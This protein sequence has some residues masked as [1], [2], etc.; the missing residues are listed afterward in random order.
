MK[1]MNTNFKKLEAD[2]SVAKNVNNLLMKKSVEIE[3]QCS[4]DAQEDMWIINM[5]N[6]DLLE[7]NKLFINESLC[8]ECKGI[9]V[10]C[11]NCGTGSE[12]I[13]SFFTAN[14]ILKFRFK[15]SYASAGWFEKFWKDLKDFFPGVD[16]DAL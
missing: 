15:R 8:S 4:E 5:S 3:Q 11:K 2:V 13:S 9:W 14:G 16:I 7:G 12:Y 1:A 10:I 6:L